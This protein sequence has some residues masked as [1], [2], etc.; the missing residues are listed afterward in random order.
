MPHHVTTLWHVATESP[1]QAFTT[2]VP[3]DPGFPRRVLSKLYPTAT[4]SQLGEFPLNRSASAGEGE[5]YIGAFPGLTVIQTSECDALRPSEIDEKWISLVGAPDVYAF[6]FDADSEVS[7]FAHWHEGKLQRSF[8]AANNRIVED[9]GIP[10]GF[11]LPF[12]SGERPLE[13]DAGDDPLALPFSPAE[14]LS[15][16]H[17]EWLGFE[18][19]PD[20]LDVPVLGYA[21]DGRREVRAAH[22]P[23][24]PAMHLSG[25]A[26]HAEIE[27]QGDSAAGGA[28]EETASSP[29]AHDDY[30]RAAAAKEQPLRESARAAASRAKEAGGIAAR[31]MGRLAKLTKD[32][33]G[34][35]EDRSRRER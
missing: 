17:T 20:G 11:E 35:L 34:R 12:W 21:T 32:Q 16:A 30:E 23:T 25:D 18:L 9:E 31:G 8:S 15:T 26:G 2:G 5:I 7:A 22:P 10:A 13:E 27:E 4:I 1:A 28:S 6:A 24:G 3:A 14:L 33:I 29:Y 19:S